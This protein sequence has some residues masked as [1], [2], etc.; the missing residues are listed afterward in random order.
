MSLSHK[1]VYAFD[2]DGN[3]KVIQNKGWEIS[4]GEVFLEEQKIFR[5]N[6][7]VANAEPTKV[8]VRELLVRAKER[9]I[10]QGKREALSMNPALLNIWVT[11][12]LR[13]TYGLDDGDTLKAEEVEE[14]VQTFAGDLLSS[15]SNSSKDKEV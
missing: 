14:L 15:L 11:D 5:P 10:Q 3:S 7:S 4:L 2:E 8:F 13:D 9:G 6:E 12:W 1:P